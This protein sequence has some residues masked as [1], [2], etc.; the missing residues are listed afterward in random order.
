MHSCQFMNLEGIYRELTLQK[1]R[2]LGSSHTNRPSTGQRLEM[3]GTEARPPNGFCSY[4]RVS[5]DRGNHCEAIEED[6]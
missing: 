2:R 4:N 6:N 3:K 5:A 1:L